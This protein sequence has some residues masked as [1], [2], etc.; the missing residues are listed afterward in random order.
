MNPL[1][2]STNDQRQSYYLNQRNIVLNSNDRNERIWPNANHFEI[3]L[4]NAYKN[5]QSAKIANIILPRF[6]ENTFSNNNQNTKMIVIV[7]ANG[8]PNNVRTVEIEEGDYTSKYFGKHVKSSFEYNAFK[9]IPI[10][11]SV[12]FDVLYNEV[13]KKLTI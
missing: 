8:N 7:N 2:K 10:M 5:V 12:T 4:P 6:T 13:T 9:N 11:I 1:Q 3:T